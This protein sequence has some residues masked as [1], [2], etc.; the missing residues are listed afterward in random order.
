MYCSS[1][2]V[3]AEVGGSSRPSE[4]AGSEEVLLFSLPRTGVASEKLE[5]RT[6]RGSLG[7]PRRLVGDGAIVTFEELRDPADREVGG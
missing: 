7:T 4:V 5:R 1:C 2:F 3:R 6:L